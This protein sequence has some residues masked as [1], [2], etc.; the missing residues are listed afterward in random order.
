MSGGAWGDLPATDSVPSPWDGLPYTL[1]DAEPSALDDPPFPAAQP[2]EPATETDTLRARMV[3]GG[4]YVFDS[5]VTADPLVGTAESPLWA[6]GEPLLITAAP[7]IGKTTLAQRLT[8]AQIGIGPPVVLGMPVQ[9]VSRVLWL[10][11]DRPRQIARSLRRMVEPTDRDTL[12]ARVL[13]WQGPPPLDIARHPSILLDLARSADAAV[14]YVDSLKDAAVGLSSDDVGAGVNVAFQA[15]VADGR[16][17]CVLHHQVKRNSEGGKPKALA[18]VYG[19][20]WITAGAGSVVLLHGEQGVPLVEL[21]HLKTVAEPVG[22]LRLV[23]DM[24]TGTISLADDNLDALEWLRARPSAVPLSVLA[25][26]YAASEGAESTDR[27]HT[28]RARR[29][30]DRLVR[31]GLAVVVHRGSRGGGRGSNDPSTYAAAAIPGTVTL[32]DV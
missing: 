15:L 3:G 18:D 1:D 22:P 31:A 7:G 8:L 23:V 28:E 29:E 25:T 24:P 9:P 21:T 26:A 11:M 19:S 32:D 13:V 20:T 17:L 10:A 5:S 27:R 30:L 16:D 4:A 2:G 12:D 6:R 14:V